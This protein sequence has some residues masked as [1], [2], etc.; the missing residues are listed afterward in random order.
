MLAPA[1]AGAIALGAVA[2]AS[3]ILPAPA[4]GS[5]PADKVTV[6][7]SASDGLALADL[8]LL[9]RGD[10]TSLPVGGADATGKWVTDIP[11]ANRQV[12]VESKTG[13]PVRLAGPA[14]A[15]TCSRA[16][17]SA[18]PIKLTVE[19]VQVV[20]E[21]EDGKV[22]PNAGKI[23]IKQTG[24][25]SSSADVG[26]TGRYWPQ[27]LPMGAKVCLNPSPGWKPARSVTAGQDCQT[28]TKP[29]EDVLF[30]LVRS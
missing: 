25:A 1:Y 19:Q 30:R 13:R 5:G 8:T 4:R 2:L 20:V 3:L 29:A 26:P 17:T 28:V 16:V 14:P 24:G 21:S 9:V 18:E 11:A 23:V 12:C 10:T 15:S 22:I 27:T 7:V 6:E